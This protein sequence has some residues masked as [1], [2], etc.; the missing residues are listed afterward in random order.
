MVTTFVYLV[1][2]VC[3]L[4]FIKVYC[5]IARDSRGGCSWTGGALL[6]E[7]GELFPGMPSGPPNQT[8]GALG[9]WTECQ[10]AELRNG[11]V[12]LTSRNLYAPSSGLGG[13]MFARSDDGD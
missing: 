3:A 11:S 8:N 4:P 7:P 10:V 1:V 9:G 6:P 13:R 12:L 5:P 2:V